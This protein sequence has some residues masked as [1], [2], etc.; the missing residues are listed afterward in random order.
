MSLTKLSVKKVSV[1]NVSFYADFKLPMLLD[2]NEDGKEST[3]SKTSSRI[4]PII[5][6][7]NRPLKRP[8]PSPTPTTAE[9]NVSQ[10][11]PFT[12]P[13]QRQSSHDQT[14]SL[15]PGSATI[16]NPQSNADAALPSLSKSWLSL[17]KDPILNR[18]I[19]PTKTVSE[20]DPRLNRSISPT[21]TISE[22]DPRLNRSMSPHT[23]AGVEVTD[24][25]LV[26]GRSTPANE[27]TSYTGN[28]NSQTLLYR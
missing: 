20:R 16:A 17:S 8:L 22:R 3:S 11:K 19:S 24:P 15:R 5:F 10:L 21:K 9:R 1:T 28:S 7:R 4:S 2:S 6:E 14:G 12:R 25:R 27:S 13:F 26:R 18:S 23:A